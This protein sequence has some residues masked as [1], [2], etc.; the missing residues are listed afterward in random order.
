MMHESY[1]DPRGEAP[2]NMAARTRRSMVKREGLLASVVRAAS[3]VNNALLEHCGVCT[4]YCDKQVQ[5]EDYVQQQY[6]VGVGAM[7]HLYSQ[8]HTAAGE[9]GAD[10]GLDAGVDA[11]AETGPSRQRALAPSP[12]G[13]AAGSEPSRGPHRAMAPSDPRT[14]EAER[15]Y[16]GVLFDEESV[17][18]SVGSRGAVDDGE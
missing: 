1:P 17:V 7:E 10:A 12:Q 18:R 16:R 8:L 4:V 13:G 14:A 3:A 2:G 5:Y 9:P 6:E 15:Y 11:N